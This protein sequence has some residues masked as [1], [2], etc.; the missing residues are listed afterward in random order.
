MNFHGRKRQHKFL[1]LEFLGIFFSLYKYFFWNSKNAQNQGPRIGI[2]INTLHSDLKI[3]KKIFSPW[4]WFWYLLMEVQSVCWFFTLLIHRWHFFHE[5]FG[6]SKQGTKSVQDHCLPD[7]TIQYQVVNR[8][9]GLHVCIKH[10]FECWCV[11][12]CC[13]H[14]HIKPS[15]THVHH[16]F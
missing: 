14:H 12:L 7:R 3:A 8:W 4:T 15:S 11:M 9:P 10:A 5:A 16:S 13:L 2:Y 1:P 6:S